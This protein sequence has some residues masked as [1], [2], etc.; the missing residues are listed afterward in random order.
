MS[1]LVHRGLH[2]RH[3]TLRHRAS[4]WFPLA[5][6]P[7]LGSPSRA[8]HHQHRRHRAPAL[9]LPCPHLCQ[10][11]SRERS[12]TPS[13]H[14][15]LQVPGH[16]LLLTGTPW[17]CSALDQTPLLPK[18]PRQPSPLRP[19]GFPRLLL[20]RW[21]Q[22]HRLGWFA[23]TVAAGSGK[24]QRPLGAWDSRYRRLSSLRPCL[25]PQSS[26]QL[27]S[28][29]SAHMLQWHHSMWPFTTTSHKRRMSWSCA[30]T[31]STRSPRSA[32]M[33]GSRALP[34]A[35]VSRGFSLETMC[36]LQSQQWVVST[37]AW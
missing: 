29:S 2:L 5:A 1:K 30:R 14:W 16:R 10:H 31:N 36:N 9:P 3:Q 4:P 6:Y 32:R 26:S 22:S 35:Q 17:R 11:A 19:A 34:C 33:V 7:L 24:W 20:P 25:L 12:V 18:A 15:A 23:A 37:K 13:Q 28:F 21:L 27:S 8:P